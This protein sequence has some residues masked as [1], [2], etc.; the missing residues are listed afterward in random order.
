MQTGIKNINPS[1]SLHQPSNLI[2]PLPPNQRMPSPPSEPS[3]DV[4][5][6]LLAPTQRFLIDFDGISIQ[7]KPFYTRSSS[8]TDDTTTLCPTIPHSIQFRS[9]DDVT[10][11][12]S[13]SIFGNRFIP[14]IIMNSI[15]LKSI[16]STTIIN[17]SLPLFRAQILPGII[18]MTTSVLKFFWMKLS[19]VF[20]T[21][22]KLP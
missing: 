7:S 5:E 22:S 10:V 11:S 12:S 13:P 17:L 6:D 15:V 4:S 14:S 20:K 1:L 18:V 8:I 19:L 9:L 16:L 2:K 3:I 21:K